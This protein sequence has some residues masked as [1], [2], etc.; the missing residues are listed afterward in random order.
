[1]GMDVVGK[2]PKTPRGEYFRANVWYWRPLW[3]LTC[4]L[5]EDIIPEETMDA[6]HYNDG[7]GLEAG[8]A[9]KLAQA[10]YT[11]LEN[12][13]VDELVTRFNEAKA[14]QPRHDCSY[15]GAT[16]IRTDAVGIAQGFPDKELDAE[17]AMFTGRMHGWCNSCRG[18]GTVDSP[19]TWY[20]S[21]TVA[22][23]CVTPGISPAVAD[24]S[25]RASRGIA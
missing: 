18:L 6:C 7:K 16:G 10:I 14:E 24:I 11:A 25:D 15:C 5:G 1:M 19:A 9:L 12:G 22:P 8:K 3:Q 21:A 2:M 4:A 20:R 23:A 13:V 17:T